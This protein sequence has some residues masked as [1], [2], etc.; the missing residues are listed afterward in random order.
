MYSQIDEAIGISNGSVRVAL[1]N[2]LFNTVVMPAWETWKVDWAR[3]QFWRGVC[4]IG[5]MT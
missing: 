1:W 3:L 2:F 5:G 4:G